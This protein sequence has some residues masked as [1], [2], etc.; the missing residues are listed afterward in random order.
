MTHQLARRYGTQS[1]T[2]RS[3]SRA[4]LV[5]LATALAVAGCSVTPTPD[6]PPV[7]D[8]SASEFNN[9][10]TACLTAGSW[11][12]DL[13]R[14]TEDVATAAAGGALPIRDVA[15][16][17]SLAIRF[18]EDFLFAAKSLDFLT[19]STFDNDGETVVAKLTR[20]E[21]VTGEWDWFDDETLVVSRVGYL[22][23][24]NTNEAIVNGETTVNL[25]PPPPRFFLSDGAPFTVT[26][27]PDQLV[28][29]SGAV[30]AWT[31]VRG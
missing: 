13:V 21:E 25:F 1:T 6:A 26:C 9:D 8:D 28:L 7:V 30:I 15:A 27:A 19:E 18:T 29:D 31:F 11:T 3:R 22:T 2:V 12:L 24:S 17:G 16:S 20:N 5:A 10:Q 14:Y 23:D 4:G